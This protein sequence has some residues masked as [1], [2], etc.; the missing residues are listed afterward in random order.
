[1][2][3]GQLRDLTANFEPKIP[4]ASPS[5]FAGW[6][7]FPSGRYLLSPT[8]DNTVFE[9]T[10]DNRYTFVASNDVV[11]EVTE[12]LMVNPKTEEL[13]IY[14]GGSTSGAVGDI[15]I[16]ELPVPAM[17]MIMG[18]ISYME[19][20]GLFGEEPGGQPLAKKLTNTT[21]TTEDYVPPFD[22]P[23]R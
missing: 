14:I 22:R 17:P 3:T 8:T 18:N 2:A 5:P 11:V 9:Y 23:A 13:S 20:G 12:S 19:A 21:D 16:I 4:L 6:K 1:M 7:R 10:L 15:L